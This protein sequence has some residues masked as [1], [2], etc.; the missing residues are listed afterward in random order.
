MPQARQPW[1]AGQRSDIR[2]AEGSHEVVVGAHGADDRGARGLAGARL[3]AEA[4]D[5]GDLYAESTQT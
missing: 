3:L 1:P 5:L 2:V 4:L